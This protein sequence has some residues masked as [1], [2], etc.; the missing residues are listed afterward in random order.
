MAAA[1]CKS[2][3]W[4]ESEVPILRALRPLLDVMLATFAHYDLS[5]HDPEADMRYPKGCGL[6][7]GSRE[8]LIAA[9]SC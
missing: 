8:G 6:F 5:G 9:S 2:Q 4:H 1:V 3:Q 7:S